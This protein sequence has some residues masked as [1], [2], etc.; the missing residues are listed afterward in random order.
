MKGRKCRGGADLLRRR[1]QRRGWSAVMPL[2]AAAVCALSL[3]ACSSGAPSNAS[4]GSSSGLNYFKGKTITWI[5]GQ[6]PGGSETPPVVVMQPLLAKALGATIKISYVPA[7]NTLAAQNEEVASAPNGLTWVTGSS[8]LDVEYIREKTPGFNFSLTNQNY[9]IGW[10]LTPQ[11][12]VSCPGSKIT[13]LQDIA[14]S[15]SPVTIITSTGVDLEFMQVIAAAYKWPVKFLTGYP[16]DAAVEDGCLRGDG[17]LATSAITDYSPSSYSKGGPVHML[18]ASVS[19]P[20]GSKYA[21]STNGVPTLASIQ[22][23]NPPA[24]NAGRSALKVLEDLIGP[25]SVIQFVAVPPKT[26]ASVIATL[27]AAFK[28]VATKASTVSQFNA[29]GVI[30]AYIPPAVV[31]AFLSKAV[32]RFDSLSPYFNYGT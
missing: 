30:P 8:L 29:Q 28:S 15:K 24:S 26:P 5:V 17:D 6:P 13:S 11:V 31:H 20:A 32:G 2:A 4:N 18:Y 21:K 23:S 1:H 10:H 22:A 16:T 9:L 19:A 14:N 12:M 25:N 27:A 7:G 3:A